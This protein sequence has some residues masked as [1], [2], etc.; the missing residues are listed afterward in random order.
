M[1]A[2]TGHAGEPPAV[3]RHVRQQ[4]LPLYSE[5]RARQQHVD[6][7]VDVQRP[8]PRHVALALRWVHVGGVD[9]APELLGPPEVGEG[10]VYLG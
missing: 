6:R 7:N 5:V 1:G 9:G 2:R 3:L 10:P 4:H 8:D